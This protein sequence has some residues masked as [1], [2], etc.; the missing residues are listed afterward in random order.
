MKTLFDIPLARN[1]D[2]IT[3]HIAADIILETDTVEKQIQLMCDLLKRFDR[4]TGW[5]WRELAREAFKYH[6]FDKSE[7]NLAYTFHRRS[8]IAKDRGLIYEQFKR[9]CGVSGFPAR[10]WRAN[11]T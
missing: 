5:T 1:T 7:D 6:K 2:P 9:I 10:A 4:E 8:S 3:S 11:A